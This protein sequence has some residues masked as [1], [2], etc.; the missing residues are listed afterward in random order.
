[1]AKSPLRRSGARGR[2]PT[3]LNDEPPVL[4][5][6]VL[7]PPLDDAEPAE[8][9]EEDGEPAEEPPPPP[10]R[11]AADPVD[12]DPPDGRPPEPALL[13]GALE[14]RDSC[15]SAGTANASAAAVM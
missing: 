3:S 14:G 9:E 2:D 13:P 15:A 1:M 7:E 6:L 10:P 5:M 12:S 8:D 4:G 11:G